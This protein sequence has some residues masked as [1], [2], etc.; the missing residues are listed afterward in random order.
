MNDETRAVLSEIVRTEGRGITAEPRRLQALLSDRAG[1]YKL[2]INLL[3]SAADEG[4]PD[5]LLRTSDTGPRGATIERL[6]HQLEESRGFEYSRSRWAVDSWAIA[7]GLDPEATVPPPGP[8]PLPGP[9]PPPPG[10]IPP[11]IPG[12]P[13]PWPPQPDPYDGRTVPRPPG[14]VPP[15]PSPGPKPNRTLLIGG[16][17]GAGVIALIVVIALLVRGPGPGPTPPTPTTR[18][19]LPPTSTPTTTPTVPLAVQALINHV[20]LSTKAGAPLRTTCTENSEQNKRDAFKGI[21]GIVCNPNSLISAFYYQLPTP[22]A[23]N[24]EYRSLATGLPTANCDPAGN[25]A[26]R[27]TNP[28]TV[29][30]TQRGFL[31]C[32]VDSNGAHLE[33]TDDALNVYGA[34]AASDSP[35]NRQALFQYWFD[36][37]VLNR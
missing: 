19:S 33:W 35:A 5:A 31:M 29:G 22:T 23:M 11:P 14:P 6:A 27:G 17:V 25:A 9:P 10:P 7:L 8:P 2:E 18:T 4:V 3:V 30:A 24:N 1:G 36:S 15:I 37:G 16:G 28:Y 13:P 21:T 12:P 20:P 34:V 26:F 32:F